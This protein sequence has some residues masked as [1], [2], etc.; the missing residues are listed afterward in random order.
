MAALEEDD[1]RPDVDRLLVVTGEILIQTREQE[2]LDTGIE[3]KEKQRSAEKAAYYPKLSGF[4]TAQYSRVIAAKIYGPH[5]PYGYAF[6]GSGGGYRTIGSIENT[7][8]VWD[9]VV[10]YVIGSTMALPNVFSVRMHAMR[11]L[12]DRFPQIVDALEPGGSGD[13]YA[14]LSDEEQGALREATRMGFPLPSWFGYKT[15]GIQAFGVL[16]QGVVAADPTYFT[17][18]WTVPGYLGANPPFHY[19]VPDASGRCIWYPSVRI[20]TDRAIDT[21]PRALER[22]DELLH[23]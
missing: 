21:W 19:W 6:G 17:D 20:V 1:A 9:G 2:L 3:A 22:I 7:R 13:P 16:Y 5:R 4:A 18:F 8:G 12:K 11:T 23:G 14:G 15:M 10:P